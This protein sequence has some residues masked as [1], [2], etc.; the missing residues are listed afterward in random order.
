MQGN[1]LDFDVDERW[2]GYLGVNTLIL[3]LDMMIISNG[4]VEFECGT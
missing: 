4:Q 2:L 3:R 1:Q